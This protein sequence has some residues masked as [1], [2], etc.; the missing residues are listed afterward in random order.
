MS[1]HLLR[2]PPPHTHT[3]RTINICDDHLSF[4]PVGSIEEIEACL[5]SHSIPYVNNTVREGAISVPQFFFHD[6]DGHM[7]EL[8]PCECLPV[9]PLQR[10]PTSSQVSDASVDDIT[11]QQRVAA[12]IE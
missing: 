7:I 8:C 6:P 5:K 9:C 10:S 2:G 11:T 3:R 4:E 12:M 1:I